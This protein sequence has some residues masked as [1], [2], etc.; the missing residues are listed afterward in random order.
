MNEVS[1]FLSYIL[2]HKPESIGVELDA[3][4]WAEIR[5]LISCANNSGFRLDH[6]LL[7][8]AVNNNNKKRFNLSSDAQYIRALQGHSTNLV[9]LKHIEKEPPEYLYHGTATRSLESIYQ[10]GLIAGSR[11]HVHLSQEMVTAMSVG[12]RYGKPFVL[13]VEASRMHFH[14][15]IFFQAQNGVWL[16]DHVPPDFLCSSRPPTIDLA[17]EVSLEKTR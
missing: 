3:E 15:F 2:R 7:L 14:G 6:E 4:G 17:Q 1:K 12:G 16:T 9:R 11:H 5:S 10:Q 8:A 13:K